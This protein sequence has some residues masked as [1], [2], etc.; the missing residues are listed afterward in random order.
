MQR[1]SEYLARRRS[2]KEWAVLTILALALLVEL[3]DAGIGIKGDAGGRLFASESIVD[4]A[5]VAVILA[6]A[7][8]IRQ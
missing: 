5:D 4:L 1:I 8:L 2:G 7:W 6:A 3:L